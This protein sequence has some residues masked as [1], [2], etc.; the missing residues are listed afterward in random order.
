MISVKRCTLL[1]TLF[2]TISPLVA[3]NSTLLQDIPPLS[4]CFGVDQTFDAKVRSIFLDVTTPGNKHLDQCHLDLFAANTSKDFKL[5]YKNTA[6]ILDNYPALKDTSSLDDVFDC[7]QNILSK[8]PPLPLNGADEPPFRRSLALKEQHTERY[9][10]KWTLASERLMRLNLQGNFSIEDLQAPNLKEPVFFY[11]CGIV[12]MPAFMSKSP[13][14]K[15]NTSNAFLTSLPK[16]ISSNQLEK[17]SCPS[18]VYAGSEKGW[19]DIPHM[20]TQGDNRCLLAHFEPGVP[21]PWN[22][23]NVRSLGARLLWTKPNPWTLH[24]NH[25]VTKAECDDFVKQASE[26][27]ASP[28]TF[29]AQLSNAASALINPTGELPPLI[30]DAYK[31]AIQP[32]LKVLD[33]ATLNTL[34]LHIPTLH[35]WLKANLYDNK[36]KEAPTLTKKAPTPDIFDK[37]ILNA[38]TFRQEGLPPNAAFFCALPSEILMEILD[39]LNPID[40]LSLFAA[41]PQTRDAAILERLKPLPKFLPAFPDIR[42]KS[43]FGALIPPRK[44]ISPQSTFKVNDMKIDIVCAKMNH[45]HVLEAHLTLRRV[46]GDTAKDVLTVGPL[47]ILKPSHLKTYLP[48]A[49]LGE[50]PLLDALIQ[51]NLVHF[52]HTFWKEIASGDRFIDPVEAD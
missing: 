12:D 31:K 45:D 4:L 24:A 52:M 35:P 3:A 48:D 10:K 15:I 5:H 38:L 43:F 7:V 50:Q 32:H 16:D 17:N 18:L 34:I 41:F 42:P 19:M 13:H 51:Y 37:I 27:V 11:Q 26:V 22:I 1:G 21:N 47:Y 25:N 28:A 30:D 29:V 39:Y 9:S 20:R 36:E 44:L 40:Q 23:D 49:I 33:A 14:L 46:D 2:V 6:E 8:M